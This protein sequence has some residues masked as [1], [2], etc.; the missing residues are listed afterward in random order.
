MEV[1]SIQWRIEQK[2]EN[3]K[4]KTEASETISYYEGEKERN[5]RLHP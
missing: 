1:L 5:L 2:T 3:S 4:Q